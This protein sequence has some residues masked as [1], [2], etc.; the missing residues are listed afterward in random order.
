MPVIYSKHVVDCIFRNDYSN[1]SNLMCSPMSWSLPT[2]CVVISL[3]LEIGWAFVTTVV[4]R[5]QQIWCCVMPDHEIQNG[6]H[7]GQQPGC[8]TWAVAQDPTLR[9]PQ[10]LVSCSVVIVLKFLVILNREPCIFNLHLASKIM[11]PVLLWYGSLSGDT[12]LDIPKPRARRPATLKT[13]CWRGHVE[14]TWAGE[15]DWGAPSSSLRLLAQVAD[16]WMNKYSG[17]SRPSL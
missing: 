1:F 4:N 11:L 9:R 12:H 8:V 16:E 15:S 6:F 5:M 17:D 10:S 2:R 13:S 7:Q 14:I 3:S